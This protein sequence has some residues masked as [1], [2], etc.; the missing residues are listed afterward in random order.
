MEGLASRAQFA[1]SRSLTVRPV[2]QR[3][4]PLEGS[5][6]KAMSIL[7]SGAVLKATLV[8]FLGVSFGGHLFVRR[9]F[10]NGRTKSKPL[11]KNKSLDFPRNLAMASVLD[12]SSLIRA[13]LAGYG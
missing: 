3:E 10:D 5:S 13:L 11:E 2:E 9:R 12:R 4:R 6:E 8:P 1:Q 7:L